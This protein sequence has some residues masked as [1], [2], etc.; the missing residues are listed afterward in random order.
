MITI[1]GSG[2]GLYGYLPALVLG[3][4]VDVALPERYRGKFEAR[5]ELA[6]CAPR[7]HWFPDEAAALAV[8]VGLVLAVRPTD[9]AMWIARCLALPCLRTL[10]LEKPLAAT[11]Q[12]S[13]SLLDALERSGKS[14]MIDY[15]FAY[16]AWRRRLVSAVERSTLVRVVWKFRA[17]HFSTNID[18]WKRRHSEGGGV[19]RFY[20]IHLLALAAE[21][22]Y[23]DV[24][25]S[26]LMWRSSDEP[27]RW[28]A[29]LSGP[30]LATLEIVVE[31]DAEATEFTI[32]TDDNVSLLALRDPFDQIAGNF[33]QPQLDR[34]VSVL[35]DVCRDFVDLS[36]R[37]AQQIPPQW[38]AAVSLWQRAEDSAEG[39]ES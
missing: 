10:L 17:H 37:N 6:N 5:K 22:G 21:L 24:E 18:N 38:R 13:A 11:P 23:V 9:Q 25:F 39:A 19:L 34:R 27:D 30:R 2:F 3:C 7:V 33:S 8:S 29:Q 20:G 31:S 12:E 16:L 28:I 4:D 36:A 32:A 26:Q 1:I 14:F 15:T 35:T